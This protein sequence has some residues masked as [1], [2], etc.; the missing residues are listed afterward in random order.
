MIDPPAGSCAASS[1]VAT[2]SVALPEIGMVTVFEPVAPETAKSPLCL[3]VS[4]TVSGA[5]GTGLAVIVKEAG[6]PSVTP[7]PA[8]IETSGGGDLEVRQ[9]SIPSS[10]SMTEFQPAHRS[11]RRPRPPRTVQTSFAVMVPVGCAP[12][13]AGQE[14]RLR[15]APWCRSVTRVRYSAFAWL[16]FEVVFIPVLASFQACEARLDETHGSSGAGETG[17][18]PAAWQASI[19]SSASMTGV[20]PVHRSVP[21]IIVS[22]CAVMVPVGSHP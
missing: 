1:I 13:R 14:G 9:V 11:A 7:A 15:L 22:S 5:A 4:A 18:F 17:C 20:Q 21:R 10:T 2:D 16:A 12:C 8:A 6:L 19:P 3:T